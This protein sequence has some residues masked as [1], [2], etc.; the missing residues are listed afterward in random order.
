MA[1][2]EEGDGMK[3]ENDPN[4]KQQEKIIDHHPH[5][6]FPQ[7]GMIRKGPK[8]MRKAIHEPTQHREKNGRWNRGE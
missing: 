4:L 8:H 6:G 3:V 7:H 5:H 2:K 1:E